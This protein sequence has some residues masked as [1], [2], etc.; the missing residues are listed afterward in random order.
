MKFYKA[1]NGILYEEIHFCA[2]ANIFKACFSKNFVYDMECGY[3]VDIIS[4]TCDEVKTFDDEPTV[5]DCLNMG[6]KTRA[7]IRYY[8]IHDGVTIKESRDMVEK[9]EKDMEAIKKNEKI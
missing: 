9:I 5:I 2:M 7:I 8:H 4:L 1:K 3:D 6:M